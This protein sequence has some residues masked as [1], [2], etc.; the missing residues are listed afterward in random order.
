[1]FERYT[2]KA[3]R[4]VFFARY[5]ASAFGSPTI[6]TEHL[7]LGLLRE[8]ARMKV[9]VPRMNA[10]TIRHRVEEQVE[11]HPST[12]TSVD[13]PLSKPAKRALEQAGDEAERLAV[14]HIGTEHLLLGLLAETGSLAEKLLR[15]GGADADTIRKQSAEPSQAT[16]PRSFQRASYGNFGFRPLSP[17]TV[18][19]HGSRWNVDYV[20]DVISLVR[21]YNWHWEKANWKPRDIA[22]H[23]KTGRF[24]FDLSLAGEGG[25][26]ELVKQGWTKD[27]CFLCRWE[28]FESEDEHGKGYTNGHDW[29]CLEC[30]ERFLRRPE[31][32]SSSQ[33]EMT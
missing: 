29:L 22:K 16:E 24:S 13:L 7:L 32:F 5:E 19:I 10:E 1:M 6:D 14:P 21:S 33:S 12:S 23:R 8:E 2:E 17:E 30:C 18:E 15:E 20:R 4:V 26:F 27:H 3:R 28:L 11:R 9:W 31:W 25:D